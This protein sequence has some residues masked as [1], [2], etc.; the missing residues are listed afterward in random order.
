MGMGMDD[1]CRCTPSEFRSVW[2]AWN[3]M[4]L[5]KERESWEQLRMQCLCTLQPWSKKS[6][7][8]VDIMEFPWDSEDGKPAKESIDHSEILR[9]Y[10]AA[11]NRAG[12]K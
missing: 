8:A 10:R 6:L 3:E 1:F 11:K 9:R 2:D 4:R 12:L 7:S 5:M